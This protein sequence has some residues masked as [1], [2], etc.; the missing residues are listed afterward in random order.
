MMTKVLFYA[1][2]IGMPSSRDMLE[3]LTREKTRFIVK[4]NV[5]TNYQKVSDL[6]KKD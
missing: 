4:T 6:K 5:M 2:C 3:K 1:Y